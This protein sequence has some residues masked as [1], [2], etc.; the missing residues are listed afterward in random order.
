[1]K[2][3]LMFFLSAMLLAGVAFAETDL[4]GMP[5]ASGNVAARETAIVTAPFSGTLLPLPGS[6]S[7]PA[8]L[9]ERPRDGG[10]RRGGR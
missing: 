4:A 1:M 2:K 9:R 10:L 7:Q 8:G 5:V 6:E 3:I